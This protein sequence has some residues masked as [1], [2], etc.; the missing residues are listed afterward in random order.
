MSRL[1]THRIVDDVGH[2]PNPS[3]GMCTLTIRKP[4]IRSAAQV[5]D[6]VA[7]LRA[8]RWPEGSGPLVYAMRVTAKMTMSEHDDWTRRELPEKIPAR[9]RDWGRRAGDAICDFDD[10]PPTAHKDAFHTVANRKTDVGGRYAFLSE[11]F[12]YFGGRPLELPEHLRPIIPPVG[13]TSRP[14]MIRTWSR[15]RLG[16]LPSSRP[17]SSTGCRGRPGV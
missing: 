11:H 14:R 7:G 8:A 10:D 16:S 15:S 12:Y 13:R 6:L 17:T 9:S 5:G 2:A 3:W 1:F 4:L